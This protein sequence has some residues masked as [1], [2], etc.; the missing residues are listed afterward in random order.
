M[1]IGRKKTIKKV[2]FI[3][4]YKIKQK[5]IGLTRE[6]VDRRFFH[7]VYIM[8]AAFYLRFI[9]ENEL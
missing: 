4:C 6:S 1:I 2:L 3:L 5:I 7:K 8:I 9:T